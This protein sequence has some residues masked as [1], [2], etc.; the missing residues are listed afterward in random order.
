MASRPAVKTTPITRD[1][2]A[3]F[4][5]SHELI[6]AFENIVQDVSV[7]IPD[8]TETISIA[9]DTAQ[10]TADSG[11]VAAAAARAL[12]EALRPL[13]EALTTAPP[14]SPTA[15][16]AQEEMISRVAYLESMVARLARRVIQLE[17]G[18]P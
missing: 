13:V 18:P 6:K 14:P 16:L 2:L 15:R 17:E 1:K 12:A 9:V 3:T 7:I 10:E 4:L 8:D 11:V 5:G